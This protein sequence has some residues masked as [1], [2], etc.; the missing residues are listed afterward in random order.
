M[1]FIITVLATVVS[2]AVSPLAAQNF[3]KGLKAHDAGDYDT[4]LREWEPL[5]EQGNIEAQ[6]NLGFMYDNGQGL[7]QDKAEAVK[8]Y[9][10][11][12][13]QAH[14][15]AQLNLGAIYRNGQGVSED[16]VEAAKWYRLAAKQGNAIAQD[17]LGILYYFG[18]GVPQSNLTAH[19]WINL[20]F[21]NGVPEAGTRRDFIAE[22]MTKADISK[23]QDMAK[24]CIRRSYAKCGN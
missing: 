19:M 1:K 7:T 16:F 8:W 10:L 11:A 23:A 5:A 12:A 15:D 3:D 2:L 17:N 24:D 18:D 9:L 20:A 21:E 6:Y 4:A 22:E 14:S 13:E